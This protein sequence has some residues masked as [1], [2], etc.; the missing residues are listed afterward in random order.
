MTG[1]EEEGRGQVREEES[2]SS[3][4]MSHSVLPFVELTSQGLYGR[5]G[6][7]PETRGSP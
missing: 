7:C 3:A 4:I 5:Q 1:G 6:S 2:E